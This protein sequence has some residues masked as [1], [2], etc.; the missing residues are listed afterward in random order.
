M[1]Y[2]H[3]TWALVIVPRWG[4]VVKP[5]NP[6]SD[7]EASVKN[8]LSRLSLNIRDVFDGLRFQRPPGSNLAVLLFTLIIGAIIQK[9]AVE[10][11]PLALN[12][13]E[14]ALWAPVSGRGKLVLAFGFIAFL[15]LGLAYCR[16]R[17]TLVIERRSHTSERS[18]V[19]YLTK[20]EALQEIHAVLV[21]EVHR[22]SDPDKRTAAIEGFLRHV[23]RELGELTRSI[24]RASIAIPDSN[25]REL[26]L[27]HLAGIDSDRRNWRRFRIDS[28]SAPSVERGLAGLAWLSAATQVTDHAETDERTS[29]AGENSKDPQRKR[30]YSGIIATPITFNQEQLGILCIDSYVPEVVRSKSVQKFVE[31]VAD[32]LATP[33]KHAL[34]EASVRTGA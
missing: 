4:C 11:W 34:G 10:L 24:H 9:Y 23:N 2:L 5:S 17:W 7:T 16:A 12:E 29:R 25:Q 18:Q 30:P 22:E 27:S 14:T 31:I 13:F 19:D 8:R 1:I 33:M 26:K 15:Y 32:L 28:A 6:E 20:I 3:P 21:E